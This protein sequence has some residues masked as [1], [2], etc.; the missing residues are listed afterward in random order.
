MEEKTQ[1]KK[2]LKIILIII[3][4]LM[5]IGIGIGF[6]LWKEVAIRNDNGNAKEA[7]YMVIAPE[8]NVAEKVK[9]GFKVVETAP[10]GTVFNL[11]REGVRQNGKTYYKI[12][13]SSNEVDKYKKNNYYIES[14][15]EYDLY[16]TWYDGDKFMRIFPLKEV[17]QLPTHVKKA[18]V[19]SMEEHSDDN[20]CFTQDVNRV[21]SSVIQTDFNCDNEEDFAIVVERANQANAL[22]IL[23]YNKDLNQSYSAYYDYNGGIATI[24]FFNKGATIYMNS[25]QLVKAP[26][27]GVMYESTQKDGYKYAVLYD[28]TTMQFNQYWQRPLSEIQNERED[29]DDSDDGGYEFVEEVEAEVVEVAHD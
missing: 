20:F 22:H 27:C 5:L 3:S 7:D 4:V 25:E 18:L 21:K 15:D 10:F 14:I 8:L 24:R 26:N 11:L 19:K 12:L 9:D 6:L 23:C 17:Q 1:Q 29:Y 16:G 2:G 28:P 13:S